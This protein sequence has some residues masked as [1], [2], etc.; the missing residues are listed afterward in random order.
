MYCNKK[1][2]AYGE[3]FLSKTSLRGKSSPDLLNVTPFITVIFP[4]TP[5]VCGPVI[6]HSSISQ[7]GSQDTFLGTRNK[8]QS[9]SMVSH[10]LE[11]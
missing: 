5:N 1:K 6:C 8:G 2:I 4:S 3:F 7:F 11:I 10:I 9:V